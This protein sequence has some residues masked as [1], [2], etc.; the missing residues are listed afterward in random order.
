MIRYFIRSLPKLYPP[1]DVKAWFS[2]NPDL[3]QE[4]AFRNGTLQ[5]AY[6]IMAARALGIDSGAMS[7]FDK[8]KID[9]AF[10]GHSGW[11]SNFLLNLGH[12]KPDHTY[13]E[14]LPKLSFEEAAIFA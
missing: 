11:K 8:G 14:R 7:G 6:L 1:A 5:G 10:F 3:A 2:G 9:Q 13:F 12:A 4:T